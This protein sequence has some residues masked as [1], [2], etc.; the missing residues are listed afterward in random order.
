MLEVQLDLMEKYLSQEKALGLDISLV[1]K[2]YL[3][4]I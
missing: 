3:S 1:L 2:I 4:Q